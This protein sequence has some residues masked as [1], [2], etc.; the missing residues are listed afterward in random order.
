M[1]S[2]SNKRRDLYEFGF[3]VSPTRA[4]GGGGGWGGLKIRPSPENGGACTSFPF[5]KMMM[6]LICRLSLFFLPLNLSGFVHP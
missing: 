3:G 2:S 4:L 5:S 6:M 1:E